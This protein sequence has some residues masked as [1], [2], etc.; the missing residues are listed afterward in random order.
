MAWSPRLELVTTTSSP[1]IEETLPST[2]KEDK[3]SSE[4]EA[5]VKACRDLS[6]LFAIDGKRSCTDVGTD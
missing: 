4:P 1:P 5:E 2:L 6:L 3:E